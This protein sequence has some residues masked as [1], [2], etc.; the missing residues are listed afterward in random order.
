MHYR[1]IRTKNDML[2][3]AVVAVALIPE[4]IGF[5]LVANFDPI[6]GLYT[7]FIWDLSQ[8]FLVVSLE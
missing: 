3:G 5:A 6:I 7:A 2:S 4:A 1:L 8:L